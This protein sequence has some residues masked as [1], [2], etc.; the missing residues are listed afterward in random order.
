MFIQSN[1]WSVLVRK[2]VKNC[3]T[4]LHVYLKMFPV[5]HQKPCLWQCT[6]VS[7]THKLKSTLHVHLQDFMYVNVKLWKYL[8]L[9]P[10]YFVKGFF[11]LLWGKTI[12]SIYLKNVNAIIS[13]QNSKTSD[14]DPTMSR[15][16]HT[17]GDW[18][19]YLHN[20]AKH[21]LFSYTPR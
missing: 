12:C 9:I 15:S 5:K 1:S 19:T 2:G 18:A 14:Y 10:N 11:S 6:F 21:C 3:F 4:H 16:V 13:V 7:I 17:A 8:I 20:T